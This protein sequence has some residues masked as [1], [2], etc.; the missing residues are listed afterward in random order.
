MTQGH[1]A[2]IVPKINQASKQAWFMDAFRSGTAKLLPDSTQFSQQ[3]LL[4][5]LVLPLLAFW[6][7]AF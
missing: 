1:A 3:A 7:L 4:L 2:D 5:Q 6:L